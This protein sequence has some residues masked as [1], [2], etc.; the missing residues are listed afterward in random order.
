[1]T[2]TI[3]RSAHFKVGRTNL[4]MFGEQI[5]VPVKHIAK[6]IAD[7]KERTAKENIHLNS[8]AV[9][10]FT[11]LL[12]VLEDSVTKLNQIVKDLKE[13]LAVQPKPV[14][15]AVKQPA[16]ASN[17]S[18]IQDKLGMSDEDFMALLNLARKEQ[19]KVS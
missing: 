12:P 3:T 18:N 9:E 17:G 10:L 4:P 1:M 16:K 6:Y 14:E 13:I 7:V 8:G 5:Q 19:A 15:K 11:N 2:K